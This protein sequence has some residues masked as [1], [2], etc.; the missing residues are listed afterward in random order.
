MTVECWMGLLPLAGAVQLTVALFTPATAVTPSGLPGE[1]WTVT[2]ALDGSELRPAIET[3]SWKESA[4][5]PA[6]ATKLTFD[7]SGAAA[8]SCTVGPESCSQAKSV[9]YWLC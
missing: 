3:T 1:P 5:G 8:A 9:A 4:A 7:P 2:L 6:G